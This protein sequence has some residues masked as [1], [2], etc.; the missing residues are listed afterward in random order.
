[1]S[2]MPDWGAVRE[3]EI[4]FNGE[5]W[6]RSPTGLLI[7]PVRRHPALDHD[8]PIAIGLFAGAGG[9][10]LGLHQAGFHVVA[11]SDSDPDAAL[12]YLTNL[13]AYPFDMRFVDGSDHDAF[14]NT[15]RRSYGLKKGQDAIELD[16]VP[17]VAGSGWLSSQEAAHGH[18]CNL[19]WLGDCRK[20]KGSDFLDP[21]GLKPGDVDLVVG[22]PPCQGFS[23]SGQRDIMDPR[24]SLVFEFTRLVS[25][26]QPKAL[27]MENV[28]G[29]ASMVTPEGI[30]V[31][32]A[33][34]MDLEGRGY[35]MRDALTRALR[36]SSG[37]GAA[38]KR[39]RVLKQLRDDD[40][41]EDEADDEPQIAMEF[42]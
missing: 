12:T 30:N 34:A 38:T 16:H 41:G 19:Y 22:G 13:G 7:P 2:A 21:L 17:F 33:I 37:A 27:C 4:A 8:L 31:V 10:D 24:N 6:D 20:L 18:G 32:D 36:A 3:R 39:G 28:P 29:M 23:H 11:A 15:L 26:I 35:G 1:M 25:E 5:K 42:A 14:E 40:E 9:F